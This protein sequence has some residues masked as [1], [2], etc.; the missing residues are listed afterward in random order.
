M[1]YLSSTCSDYQNDFFIDENS[2]YAASVETRSIDSENREMIP[3]DPLHMMLLNMVPNDTISR[4]MDNVIDQSD[5]RIQDFLY[6]ANPMELEQEKMIYQ[7][8]T[9]NSFLANYKAHF[10]S[11][12]DLIQTTVNQHRFVAGRE[13]SHFA[14]IAITGPAKSG[15]S[16]LLA[17]LAKEFMIDM[18]HVGD[19][20][21]TFFVPID[22]A[23]LSIHVSDKKQFLEYMVDLTFDMIHYQRPTAVTKNPRKTLKSIF[24]NRL[25]LP[26][27][28]PRFEEIADNL[29]TSDME[30][31]IQLVLDLPYAIS[32]IYGFEHV[33]YILDNFEFCDIVIDGLFFVE[34]VKRM[35]DS[36]NYIISTGDFGCLEATME[37]GIYLSPEFITTYDVIE[38]DEEQSLIFT[39]DGSEEKLEVSVNDC[40]G[41]APFVDEWNELYNTF[42]EYEKS[43]DQ[44]EFLFDLLGKAHMFLNLVDSN[45]HPLGVIMVERSASN[46]Q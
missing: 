43:P 13:V 45:E 27:V 14:R 30:Y 31:F 3:F 28:D 12:K 23:S 41:V 37:N 22:I 35:I 25:K 1:S 19:A 5:I 39:L 33:F 42:V 36:E 10:K 40:G 20:K 34:N 11:Y 46:A 15:K 6:S 8:I 17:H 24:S 29:T 38:V 2:T 21:K 9:K 18:L 32:H 7:N 44:D 26:E 16:T 4:L